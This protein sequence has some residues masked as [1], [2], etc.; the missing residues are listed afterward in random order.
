MRVQTVVFKCTLQSVELCIH[1]LNTTISTQL[2][3]KS[4]KLSKMHY[5]NLY[6]SRTLSRDVAAPAEVPVPGPAGTKMYDDS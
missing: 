2:G 4:I 6:V 3:C 1:P 5:V